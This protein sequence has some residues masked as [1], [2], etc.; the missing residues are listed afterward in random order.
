MTSIVHYH[1]WILYPVKKRKP[2]K[3]VQATRCQTGRRKD[4]ECG[5]VQ[6][7]LIPRQ[8]PRLSLALPE[9]SDVHI[10]KYLDILVKLCNGIYLKDNSKNILPVFYKNVEEENLVTVHHIFRRTNS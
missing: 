3:N 10:S 8:C 6:P 2:L 7:L 1:G 5:K 9:L 4:S